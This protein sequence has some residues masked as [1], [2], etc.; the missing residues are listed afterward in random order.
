MYCFLSEIRYEESPQKIAKRNLHMGRMIASNAP[1]KPL[2]RRMLSYGEDSVL[3]AAF[4]CSSVDDPFTKYITARGIFNLSL[5]T[6]LNWPVNV[7]LRSRISQALEFPRGEGTGE[8][9]AKQGRMKGIVSIQLQY[10]CPDI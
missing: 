8:D 7:N 5:N 10:S 6:E 3:Q 4:L 9:R 2:S 1:E